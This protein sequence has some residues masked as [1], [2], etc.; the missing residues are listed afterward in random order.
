MNTNEERENGT[1]LNQMHKDGGTQ[2]DIITMSRLCG[3]G[4]S[5]V[6]CTLI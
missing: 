6:Y 3:F 4:R 1:G 2:I 5:T